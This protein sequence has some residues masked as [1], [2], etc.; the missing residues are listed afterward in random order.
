[1]VMMHESNIASLFSNKGHN[2][3]SISANIGNSLIKK[4]FSS[5]FKYFALGFSDYIRIRYI[6]ALFVKAYAESL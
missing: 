3:K 2:A 1:M 4:V 6:D 5:L